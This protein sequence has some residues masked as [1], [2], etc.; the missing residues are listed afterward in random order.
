MTDVSLL[1][2]HSLSGICE[3]FL[4]FREVKQDVFFKKKSITLATGAMVLSLNTTI[5]KVH[6]TNFIFSWI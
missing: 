5:V 3:Q 6:K 4:D 2:S 1:F